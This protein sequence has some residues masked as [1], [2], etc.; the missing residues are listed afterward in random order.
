MVRVRF[1]PSPTG[2]LHIGNARTAL[3]NWLFARANR[4]S[5]ILRIEDT[6]LERSKE[7]YVANI[8]ED[9]KWLGIDW[10]E[11]PDIGGELGPYRQSERL[12]IYRFLSYDLIRKGKAYWCYCS[13]KELKTRRAAA[14][15]ANKTYKYD[16]RCRNLPDEE[17]AT[18]AAK[19]V[20][21]SLRFK[22]PDKTIIID[23]IVRGKVTFDASL[24]GDFI[25]MKSTNTPSFNFAVVCDDIKMK[26]SHIIR[27]EDH[28]SNT[29]KH[30]LLFEAFGIEPPKF[31]HM[32]LT[33]AHGGD[34]LSKRTGATSIAHYRH[35]GY[36]PEAMC[37]YLALLGWSPGEDKEVMTRE[38]MIGYF[39]LERLSRASEAFDP[40]KLNWL[41][42]L[43]IR[44][45]DID[46]LTELC[47]PYLKNA[48]FI[49]K[50]PKG[51]ELERLKSI[52]RTV[53]DHLSNLSEINDHV[54]L[55]FADKL[56][57]ED[58]KAKIVMSSM[59]SQRII[60]TLL[61]KMKSTRTIDEEIFAKFMK[62]IQEETGSRGKELYQAVRLAITG[63]FHGPEMKFIAPILGRKNCIRRLKQNIYK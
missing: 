27:G 62:E 24:I 42:G 47:L 4:G 50:D 25:I 60:K 3:F 61:R 20:K 58:Q 1:A 8:I 30:V 12:N 10:D 34:R 39:K 31:A 7:D 14:L 46:R 48:G 2:Y 37:N 16:N 32:S 6:D 40:V 54:G 11:G 57:I 33:R 9:L 28:L 18:L 19:G 26:I 43:Y 21:P 36:L 13:E 41:S 55:F 22:V 51:A 52:V 38:E 44:N 59:P 63:R 23:D 17:R 5:F 45:A 56:E 29:P 49:K 53:R 35:M 15:A